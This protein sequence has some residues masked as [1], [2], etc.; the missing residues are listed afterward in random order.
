MRTAVF[1]DQDVSEVREDLM[2]NITEPSLPPSTWGRV[3]PVLTNVTFEDV[4]D[5]IFN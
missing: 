1:Q 5:L 2:L 3:T 4:S